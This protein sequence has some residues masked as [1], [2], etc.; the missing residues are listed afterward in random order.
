MRI[1]PL[2]L[3][4]EASARR[5]FNRL[6]VS[7]QGIDILAP[8]SIY[9]AF[10]IDN[11]T[12]WE[13]N[14]IKQEMLSLGSDAALNRN[15]LVKKVKADIIIFGS[16]SQLN[17]LSEKLKRQPFQL[18]FLSQAL[19]TGLENITK[20]N[21]QLHARGRVLKFDKPVVCGI[22]NLT[23]DSFSGD[24]LLNISGNIVENSLMQTEIMV[25]AGAQMID[26]GAQSSR[27][28]SKPISTQ[29]ELKR[30]VPVVKA[31]RKEFKNIFLSIDTYRC[32]VAGKLADYGI[33]IINDITAFRHAPKMAQV[34]KK[35]K[36]G[37][38]L[39]HMQKNPQTMQ[40]NPRYQD[41]MGELHDFFAGR[42]EF[43]LE[44]G[45]KLESVMIDP[46]IGFG[47]TKEHNFTILNNLAQLKIFGC[48]IFLGASRKKFLGEKLEA[49]NRLAA[50]IAANV[51]GVMQ[52]AK[53]LRVHDCLAVTQAVEI[54]SQVLNA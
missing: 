46:G 53:V 19:K 36:L 17:K 34:V 52:G 29:D 41:L 28:F 8:K 43:A 30:L 9:A 33:D 26:I 10:K 54:I 4:G 37:C 32:E 3:E 16:L 5:W 13:A 42:I 11:L 48:P 21:L 23:N 49:K 50:T 24:G 35:Y 40:A 39:M 44:Q 18:G 45:I 15:V 31:V 38:V 25:N 47:K 14:I 2:Q 6:G 22:L 1:T 27:P 12:S 20:E 51:L 7:S